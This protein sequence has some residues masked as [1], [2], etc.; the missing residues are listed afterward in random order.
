M[1]QPHDDVPMVTLD[2][3]NYIMHCVLIDNGSSVDI[4]YLLAFNQM[5]IRRDKLKSVQ[6]PLA[7]FTSDKLLPLRTICLLVTS[8]VGDRQVTQ[9]VNFLVVN[10]LSTYSAILRRPALN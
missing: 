6:T 3:S 1:S 8:K 5:G 2:I 7:G 9:V 10:C 4:L